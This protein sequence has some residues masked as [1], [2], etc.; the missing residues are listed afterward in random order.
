MN[1]DDI[2]KLIV[3]AVFGGAVYYVKK[4]KEKK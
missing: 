4:Q 1:I 2:V 3:L